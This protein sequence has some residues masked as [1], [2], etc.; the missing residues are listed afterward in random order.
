MNQKRGIVE[1]TT[2]VASSVGLSV[3]VSFPIYCGI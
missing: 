3:W 1:A 2:K